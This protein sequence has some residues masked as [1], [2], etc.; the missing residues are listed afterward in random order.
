MAKAIVVKAKAVSAS[1]K[2]SASTTMTVRRVEWNVLRIGLDGSIKIPAVVLSWL[3]RKANNGDA[4]GIQEDLTDFGP[5]RLV[6]IGT[7]ETDG[8]T[9]ITLSRD[10][11]REA[12]VKR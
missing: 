6:V 7:C 1:A 11:R 4:S 12:R 2:G 9:E 8:G 5:G 10:R 3:F